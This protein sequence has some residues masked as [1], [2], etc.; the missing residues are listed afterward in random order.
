VKLGIPTPV[1][2]LPVFG[3]TGAGAAVIGG[4]CTAGGDTG[5]IGACTTPG[6]AGGNTI[7]GAGIAARVGVPSVKNCL[8]TDSGSSGGT[9]LY[10]GTITG[11]P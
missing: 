4:N 2:K 9:R 11:S 8:V 6:S 1:E 3:F 10:G 5:W 7:L